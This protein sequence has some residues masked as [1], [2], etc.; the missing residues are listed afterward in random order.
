MSKLQKK[1]SMRRTKADLF[2]ELASG[3]DEDGFTR[4]VGV[5][6]FSGK[7]SSLVFGNGADWARSD[8]SL[9]KQYNIARFKEG[10]GN[11]ITHVQLQG[12]NKNPKQRSVAAS[13][14][15]YYLGQKCVVL[16]TSKDV[17]IDHK[18][19]RYDDPTVGYVQSQDPKDFQP[20]SKAANYAKRQHCK[21]CA[22][23]NIRF[24]ATTLGYPVPHVKGNSQYRGT[25]VGCFW[26]DPVAFRMSLRAN[27]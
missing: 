2:V 9:G 27:M 7:Y 1:E 22:E 23:T 18:D 26:Y 15:N 14:R 8:G 19:G 25:C 5:D 12:F 6:E 20:L 10:K 3:I 4:K 11:R 17:E 24:D 21:R 13:V 16:G